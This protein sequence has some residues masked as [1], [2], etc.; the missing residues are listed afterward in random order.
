MESNF[1]TASEKNS[2]PLVKAVL[3]FTPIYFF[4]SCYII[5]FYLNELGRL[6]L[7]TTSLQNKSDL[8]ASLIS[9]ILLSASFSIITFI[10]SILLYQL[11][12]S[13]QTSSFNKVLNVK[14]IPLIT[15]VSSL[16][17]LIFLSLISWLDYIPTLIKDYSFIILFTSLVIISFILTHFISTK[18]RKPHYIY[19]KG[20]W[21]KRRYFSKERVVTIFMVAFSGATVVF[22]LS[23]IFKFGNAYT[24]RGI[25][26]ALA[27]SI[28]ISILSLMPAVFLYSSPMVGTSIFKKLRTTLI[29][30][31]TIF[32]LILFLMPN[33]VSLLCFG[34]F[35]NIGIMDETQHIYVIAKPYYSPS[36]FPSPVWTHIDSNDTERFYLKGTSLF[37]LGES[38][39]LCPEFVV[40]T[41]NKFLKKNFDK[42]FGD[43][44]LSL[45]HL[46]TVARSCVPV[47]KDH[48]AQWDTIQDIGNKLNTY[49]K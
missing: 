17:T 10:P 33:L 30:S 34:A 7:F 43:N 41:K 14:K 23:L 6:S 27:L 2:F 5:W 12:F 42:I 47:K 18:K 39:L 38:V 21:V 37:S 20:N 40:K 26:Y 9:F 11:H 13:F 44:D 48:I 25:L 35:K 4:T 49:S 15:I 22:P 28:L 45:K 3:S 24:I 31:T 46:K 16:S 19:S 29:T 36:M 8:F 32:I 1:I